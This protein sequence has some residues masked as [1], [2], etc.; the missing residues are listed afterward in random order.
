MGGTALA[1]VDGLAELR[2]VTEPRPFRAVCRRFFDHLARLMEEHDADA[3]I[4]FVEIVPP[5]ARAEEFAEIAF[6]HGCP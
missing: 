3:R 5:E 2:S 6:E 4:Q 1:G